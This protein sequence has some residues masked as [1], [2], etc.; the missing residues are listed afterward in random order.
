MAHEPSFL[1]IC[2][3]VVV[4][5]V[6]DDGVVVAVVFLLLL[7]F[8]LSLISKATTTLLDTHGTDLLS[9]SGQEMFLSSRLL[10]FSQ[11]IFPLGHLL[12]A[13]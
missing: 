5:V 3:K 9:H 7:L 12:E 11:N 13:Y 1:I 8:F 4:L 6:V 2:W 10:I